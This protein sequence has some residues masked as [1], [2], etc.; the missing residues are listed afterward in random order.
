M[1]GNGREAMLQT[2]IRRL[3]R[4]LLEERTKRLKSEQTASGLRSGVASRSH[5]GGFA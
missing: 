2:T 5:A 4:E 3:E 1:T